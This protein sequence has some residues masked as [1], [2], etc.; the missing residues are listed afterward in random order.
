MG[1]KRNWVIY[2]SMLWKERKIR[3]AH[4]DWKYTRSDERLAEGLLRRE[5]ILEVYIEVQPGS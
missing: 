4:S 1:R 3:Y 5:K 2:T